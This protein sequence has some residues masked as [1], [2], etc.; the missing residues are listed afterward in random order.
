MGKSPAVLNHIFPLPSQH[1]KERAVSPPPALFSL[2][3][4]NNSAAV[5]FDPPTIYKLF[6]LYIE[7]ISALVGAYYAH[8][9]QAQY[10]HMTS[11]PTASA[12]QFYVFD[13]LA[14]VP[15]V[16]MTLS[17]L[18]NLYLLFAINEA[19]VL[20][21]TR[22]LNVWRAL[23]IGL[24]IADVGHL[25]SVMPLFSKGVYW[26]FWEWNAMYWGNIGFVYVGASMRVA[27]LAGLGIDSG[28]RALVKKTLKKQR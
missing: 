4:A 18:A 8:F 20:R 7:P 2:T 10:L 12:P 13:T 11:S 24:L 21:S 3:M 1:N 25:W 19:L 28:T 16:V 23:L 5:S 17:Q 22:D 15:T 26:R 14:K 27:F 9:Q 6:F